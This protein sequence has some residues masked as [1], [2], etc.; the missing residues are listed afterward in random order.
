MRLFV[1]RDQALLLL[2][3]GG[4]AA[5]VVVG[6]GLEQSGLLS[7]VAT[8]TAEVVAPHRSQVPLHIE[9]GGQDPTPA[10]GDGLALAPAGPTSIISE[11]QPSTTPGVGTAVT[12][13][14]SPV[15]TTTVVPPTVYAYPP[16]DHGGA[17]QSGSGSSG[18]GGSGSG[19]GTG[20]GSKGGDD[21]H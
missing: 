10:T 5:A 8:W 4:L 11:G 17:G 14:P 9:I 19:G 15:P 1:H 18:S 21:N 6:A 3:V 13:Q 12:T 20:G 16:D 7:P 2:I